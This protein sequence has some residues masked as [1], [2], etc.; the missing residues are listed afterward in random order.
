MKIQICFLWI[1]EFDSI[2]LQSCIK[3]FF[4]SLILRQSIFSNYLFQYSMFTAQK[5]F[6]QYFQ[7]LKFDS[8]N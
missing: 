1:L 3:D 7:S 8:L 2:L 6:I 5:F 4:N